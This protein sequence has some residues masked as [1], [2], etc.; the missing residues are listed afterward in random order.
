M[1]KLA[2]DT[3]LIGLISGDDDSAYRNEILSLTEWCSHHN[4]EVDF[5]RQRKETQPL[6]INAAVVERVYSFKFLATIISSSLKWEDN[7]T[8]IIRKAHQRLFSLRQLNKFRVACK[9]MQQFYRA[10]FESV[11]TFSITVWYGNSTV[12]QRYCP[13]C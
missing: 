12:Q 13:T 1:L 9:G 2:D 3:T 7:I 10:T 4:L 6:S 8:A 5:R 11:L